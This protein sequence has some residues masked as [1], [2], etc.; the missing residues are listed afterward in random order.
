MLALGGVHRSG[1]SPGVDGCSVSSTPVHTCRSIVEREVIHR[2]STST[3]IKAWCP[4]RTA[5]CAAALSWHAKSALAD[6][7]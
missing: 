7:P 1:L 2:G 6:S 5:D 4:C 3:P